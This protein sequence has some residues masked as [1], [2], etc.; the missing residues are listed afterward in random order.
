MKRGCFLLTVLVFFIN[1]SN[2]HATT[3]VK[4]TAKVAIAP[5]QYAT[6]LTFDALDYTRDML[7]YGVDSTR[8]FNIGV[9]R[10]R[11]LVKVGYFVRG[12][13]GGYEEA[14][15]AL[16]VPPQGKN[17]LVKDLYLAS[18][19]RVGKQSQVRIG[20]GLCPREERFIHHRMQHVEDQITKIFKNPI[21]EKAVTQK[22]VPR[23][24]VCASGGGFRA[25]LATA[26]ALQ[27]L[28]ESKLINLI[29][30]MSVLSGS[31]WVTIPRALGQRLDALIDGYLKYAKLPLSINPETV[32]SILAENPQM[33]ILPWGGQHCQFPEVQVIRDNWLRKFFF[34]QPLDAVD[35][36]GALVA[37]MV[38]GPFD[39]PQII[40]KYPNQKAIPIV[41]TRQRVLFSQAALNLEAN[42]FGSF[43]LPIATAVSPVK[44][45]LT[46]EKQK[47][48]KSKMMW[49]EFTPYEMGTEYYGPDGEKTGASVRMS[50]MG[51]K[52]KPSYEK[53]KGILSKIGL[54]HGT[55]NGYYSIDNAPEYSLSNLL[56]TWGSAFT[57][58]LRDLVRIL[59]F[60]S[61]LNDTKKTTPNGIF[62]TIV[63]LMLSA[64]APV[65]SLFKNTRLWPA[66]IHNFMRSIP[67][68][69]QSD[70]TLTLIDA[71]LDFNL[72]LPPLLRKARDVDVI[73]VMDAS[74]PVFDKNKDGSY[75]ITALVNA[76][77]WAQA[78][79]IKFPQIVGSEAY[80]KATTLNENGRVE[81]SVTVFEGEDGA[82][83]II[84]V[85]LADNEYTDK[86]S[87]KVA[88]CFEEDCNTFNFKYS[89][90]SVKSVVKTVSD[91]VLGNID[92][93]EK[94]LVKVTYKKLGIAI[95]DKV[96]APADKEVSLTD[97]ITEPSL[98]L[99]VP[100]PTLIIPEFQQNIA[101]AA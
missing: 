27:A 71:G 32:K 54:R 87:F 99:I 17:Q 42:D 7:M 44:G 39:D 77:N 15:E 58:S 52:F 101:V 96:E 63:G 41:E 69:P 1:F 84:F 49:Y 22:K 45:L 97:R 57:F 30:F 89:E 65:T 82:P 80:K 14:K 94:A 9:A 50:D 4:K 28:E 78:Q 64:F 43:P 35:L 74:M 56:G 23:I 38:L 36:Y 3:I 68:S 18:K 83:T 100:K 95:T 37:H 81:H 79:G 53:G 29:T 31:T 70:R 75:T 66:T 46:P 55:L 61:I 8:T 73:I 26:G 67:G 20:A 21:F 72:P 10:A 19:S 92:L 60:G 62:R 2:L 48:T 24:A 12:K 13:W 51:R 85:P 25:M 33:R 6:N 93:I 16:N 5:F 40:A 11:D 47:L 91:T 34:D 59:G 90:D 98:K 76:E 86:T 88:Q